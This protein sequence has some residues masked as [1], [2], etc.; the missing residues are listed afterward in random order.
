MSAILEVINNVKQPENG[1]LPVDKFNKLYF[2]DDLEVSDEENIPIELVGIVIDYMTRYLLIGDAKNCFRV[3]LTGAMIAEEGEQAKTLLD[4][5]DGL[6]NHSVIAACKLVAYDTYFRKGITT[7]IKSSDVNPDSKSVQNII[8][9]INRSL[10]FIKKYG[11]ITKE[12]I[13]FEG[14]YT[15]KITSGDGD[16][17]TD[18]IIWD[19]KLSPEG[20]TTTNTLQLLIHY[21]MGK[22]SN[23]VELQDVYKLGFFNPRLNI[24][25]LMDANEI[26]SEVISEVETKII[27]Y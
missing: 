26:D 7:T 9:M 14:G 25:Y 3:S 24:V 18:G 4:K 23:Y 27:G 17:V 16:F 6:N 20:I 19:F 10:L 21:I 12:G 5:I 2:N 15:D 8:N 1:Y 22:H 11:P 13:T